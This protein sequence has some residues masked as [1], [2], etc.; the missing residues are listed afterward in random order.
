[1]ANG[2]SNRLDR[3]WILGGD[4]VPMMWKVAYE[5]LFPKKSL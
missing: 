4:S 3:L 2:F 1:V 5:T